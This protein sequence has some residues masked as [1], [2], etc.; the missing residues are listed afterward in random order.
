MNRSPG[1]NHW[2]MVKLIGTQSNRDGLG[3]QLK[4]TPSG[5]SPIYN[6]ATT[7]TGFGGSSDPRVHFGLG[8]SDRVELLEI[9]W[10]SGAV[11]TLTGLKADQILTVREP[12]KSPERR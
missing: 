5:G 11:Q 12:D 2:L 8:A 9:R 1:N 6:H 10:P 4:L 3:A 7:S